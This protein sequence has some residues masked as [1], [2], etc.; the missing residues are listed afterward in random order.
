MRR[1]SKKTMYLTFDVGTTSVKTA[2]F[3]TQGNLI[4]KVI[5]DYRLNSPSVGWYEVE[6]ETYW[7][8]V[9]EGFREI[10][11]KSPVSMKNVRT[12]SGCSQ[13]ETV[14]FLDGNGRPLRPAIVWYDNR[15]RD[16]MEELRGIV[17][18]RELYETT[19]LP[20]LDPMWSANKILW[21]KKHEVQ[22]FKKIKK[23]MLVEDFIVFRLTGVYQSSASLLATSMLA[24]IHNKVYWDK[25]VDFLEVRDQLPGIIDEGSIVGRVKGEI[26]DVIGVSRDTV[27]VKGSMDQNTSAV[28]AGNIKTGI[29]TEATGSALAIAVTVGKGNLNIRMKLPY[30]PHAIPGKFIYMPFSQTAGIVYKWFRDAFA[31]EE[32][33]EVG[34]P[35]LVYE[36]L[37][38]L[39]S[40]VQPG[41]DGLIFLPYLAGASCPENDSFAKGV[42]YGITLKH[43][44]AHFTRA[45]M[46]SIAFMLKKILTVVEG[47]GIRIDEVH[48]MGG[49]A[50]SDLWLQI[51]SDVCGYPFVRMVEEEAATLGAAIIAAVS[52]GDYSSFEEAVSAMVKKGKRF[53]PDK[54]HSEVYTKNY[55]LYCE[56]YERLK[57][58]F[59]KY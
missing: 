17:T 46:E 8:A 24:D 23:I 55:T 41:S 19:G 58:L 6:P 18:D 37:N 29:I 44:R 45:I 49:G 34:D 28:G 12:I 43:G 42:F 14:I 21:V 9:M 48:S 26:A 52:V 40:S 15:A 38:R 7:N 5:R 11:V 20:E 54:A 31:G 36:E 22:L 13:G 32:L 33:K 57:P 4:H 59:R 3:D 56:L 47:A 25:T 2:L 53:I 27:V 30:Q 51:K 35:E 50:R 16:E 39:A 1:R 10:A